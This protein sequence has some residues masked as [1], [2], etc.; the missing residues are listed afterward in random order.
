MIKYLVRC[1]Y[2]VYGEVIVEADSASDARQMVRLGNYEIDYGKGADF[3]V[4]EAEPM[5]DDCQW[6]VTIIPHFTEVCDA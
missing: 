2:T 6:A 5:I 3:N 1:H 4:D